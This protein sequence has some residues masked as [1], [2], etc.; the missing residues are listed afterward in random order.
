M[1]RRALLAAGGAVAGSYFLGAS[2]AAEKTLAERL[3]YSRDDRLLI[4]HADDMGMC[5]SVNDA[6]ARAM[7]DGV[8]TCASVMVPCPWF[9]HV[10]A[11]SKEHPEADL[12][13]H[14]TLTSEWKYY[15]WRPVSPPDKVPGLIDAEGFLWR[16]V[17]EVVAHARPEEVETEIRA[18]IERARKFG[19]KPTHVD[20]HMGT[21]FSKAE[22]FQA[23][24]RA[25]RAM[26]LLPML[27]EPNPAVLAMAK[28]LGIDYKAL[29]V[30][31]N[32]QGFLLLD[33]LITGAKTPGYEGRKKEYHDMIRALKPGVT[34]IIVHL[35][36]DD[37]EIRNITGNWQYR[38]DEYRIFTDPDTRELLRKEN[39]K[40]VGYRPLANLW[41]KQVAAS[42]RK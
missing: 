36:R 3:G 5:Q 38:A 30:H 33:L 1:T 40:L 2:E 37:D 34:E 28:E 9:P 29:S 7:K 6:T 15:R 23:Y 24:V 39:I 18:Q 22:F 10:A 14:L 11:W 4:I 27:M 12:G 21:L 42:E 13:L 31:L 17:E 26:G 19:M 41:G 8:V 20:S 16:S 35:S 32:E 25:S